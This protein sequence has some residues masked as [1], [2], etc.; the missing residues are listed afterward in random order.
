MAKKDHP[1]I[2]ISYKLTL[3]VSKTIR[4]A[5]LEAAVEEARTTQPY[6]LIPF[7]EL[8]LSHDDSSIEVTGV[9]SSVTL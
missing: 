5:S 4:S 6:D 3:I 7:D 2:T 1:E 8:G 9:F